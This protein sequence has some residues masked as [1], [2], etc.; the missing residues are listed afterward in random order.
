[1]TIIPDDPRYLPDLV[2]LN[3]AWIAEH[4]CIEDADRRLADDP[5]TIL[6]NGGH[7]FTAVVNEEAIGVVA[8]FRVSAS[9]FELARMAVDPVHRGRGIGRVLADAAL[10][11]AKADGAA[12]VTLL[13]NTKLVPAIALYR[14]LGFEV[15]S[16]GTHPTYQRCNI[17][18]GKS[19]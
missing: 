14:S 10:Q 17:V 9:E 3:A 1:M 11:R 13:S 16:E 7:T 8:L 19:L 2:R 5:A 18:M 4:F 12:R 15:V 6:R